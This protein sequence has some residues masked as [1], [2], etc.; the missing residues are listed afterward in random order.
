MAEHDDDIPFDEIPPEQHG[1]HVFLTGSSPVEQSAEV[2]RE[3]HAHMYE[4]ALASHLMVRG[5]QKQKTSDLTAFAIYALTIVALRQHVSINDVIKNLRSP[6]IM[7]WREVSSEVLG[8]I[9]GE[10]PSPCECEICLEG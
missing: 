3:M 9:G 4:R 2:S 8:W 7:M 1:I 6:S 5:L 10:V